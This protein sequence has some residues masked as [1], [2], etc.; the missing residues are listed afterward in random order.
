MRYKVSEVVKEN[1]FG[2]GDGLQYNNVPI[3]QLP[4]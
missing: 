2:K 3:Y 1:I 4:E